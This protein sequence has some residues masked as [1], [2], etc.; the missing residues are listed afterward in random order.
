MNW[1]LIIDRREDKTTGYWEAFEGCKRYVT[2][3][4]RK[5]VGSDNSCSGAEEDECMFVLRLVSLLY[6]VEAA[7]RRGI[8]PNVA[9]EARRE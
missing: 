5:G 1:N 7:S 8:L 4:L 9:V 2:P 6:S 3:A